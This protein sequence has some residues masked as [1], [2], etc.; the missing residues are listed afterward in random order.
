[1]VWSGKDQLRLRSI[2]IYPASLLSGMLAQSTFF[3]FGIWVSH[4]HQLT[5]TLTPGCAGRTPTARLLP[6]PPSITQHT[7]DGIGADIRQ[8]IG[9][10][11]QCLLQRLERP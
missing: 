6:T 10:Y 9:S 2:L 1:M 4:Q 5:L 3:R 11:S 7:P 8:S